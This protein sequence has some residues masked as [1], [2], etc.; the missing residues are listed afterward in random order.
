MKQARI[1]VRGR[2]QGVFFRSHARESAQS[3]GLTGYAE[4]LPN[5]EVEILVQGGENEIMRFLGW[6]KEGPPSSDV[7]D[8]EYAWEEPTQKHEGFETY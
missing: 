6:C 7:R 1:K 4:N 8:V 3:L 2:V 5:G